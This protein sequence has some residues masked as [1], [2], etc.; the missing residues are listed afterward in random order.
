MSTKLRFVSFE[1]LTIPLQP[2][3]QVVHEFD[4]RIAKVSHCEQTGSEIWFS[5]SLA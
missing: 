1:V 4:W 3:E 2:S 5:V